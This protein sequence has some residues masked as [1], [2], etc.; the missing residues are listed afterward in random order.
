[1][2]TSALLTLASS[3]G[4]YAAPTSLKRD[5]ATYDVILSSGAD[6]ASVL[7]KLDITV[8]DESVLNTYNNSAFKVCLVNAPA[9]TFFANKFAGILRVF[10][11]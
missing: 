11:R 1:M 6:V 9:K 7:S 8:E 3:L 10:H 4:I 5:T 2:K